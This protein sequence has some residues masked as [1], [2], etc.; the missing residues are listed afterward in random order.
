MSDILR[1]TMVYI[2]SDQLAKFAVTIVA[3]PHNS[4]LFYYLVHHMELVY[5]NVR[6]A[7]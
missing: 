7:H 6:V 5:W 4:F 3:W 2:T 1:Y